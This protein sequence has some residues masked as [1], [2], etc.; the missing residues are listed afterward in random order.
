MKIF[1]IRHAESQ[2]NVIGKY[3]GILNPDLTEL[4]IKQA[5]ALAKALKNKGIKI[6]FTS[7]LKRTKKTAE[8]LAE[9][10]GVPLYEDERIIEID[11]GVWSGLKIEEVQQKFPEMYETWLKTPWNVKFPRGESLEE[12][13]K[14]VKDFL[15]FLKEEHGNENIAIVS[16]TVPIR[17]LYCAFL[18]LPLN[19]FWSFGCD[20][21]SYSILLWEENKRMI[22]KLN[23]TSHLEEENLHKEELRAL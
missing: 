9:E 5:K 19:Y 18:E 7:P 14:R 20:N 10:L 21:A 22:F 4:G 8:I 23:I 17:T 3:Q 13:Y 15:N 16:H 1:V 2:W 12:V 11:H 6:I